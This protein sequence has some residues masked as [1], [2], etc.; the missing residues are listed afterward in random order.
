MCRRCQWECRGDKQICLVPHDI[1]RTFRAPC[2]A[3]GSPAQG[4][5]ERWQPAG[6]TGTDPDLEGPPG[7]SERWQPAGYTGT[8]PDV[9]KAPRSVSKQSLHGIGVMSDAGTRAA[10][11]IPSRLL[12]SRST[13]ACRGRFEKPRG[14]HLLFEAEHPVSFSNRHLI[15][16]ISM[17]RLYPTQ[18]V[19]QRVASSRSGTR[20]APGSEDHKV[21]GR[22]A[23]LN[24]LRNWRRGHGG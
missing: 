20:I 12:A 2:R 19:V 1:G 3:T 16:L 23:S 22:G 24:R 8:D 15:A 4:Q 5:S 11:A 9:R 18:E 17:T 6:Y 21:P 10:V 13:R 7:Q 14:P